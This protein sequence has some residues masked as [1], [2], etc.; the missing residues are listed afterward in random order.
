MKK[1]ELP[2]DVRKQIKLTQQDD[3]NQQYDEQPTTLI[4][5]VVKIFSGFL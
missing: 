1:D 5:E 3:K 2:Q 4:K